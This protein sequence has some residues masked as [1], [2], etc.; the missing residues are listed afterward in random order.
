MQG[1]LIKIVTNVLVA[2]IAAF[3]GALALNQDFGAAL[4]AGAGAVVAILTGLFQ[5]KP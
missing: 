4:A 3:G 1:R 2:F 5:E